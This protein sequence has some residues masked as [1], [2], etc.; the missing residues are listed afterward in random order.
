MTLRYRIYK[1]DDA[2]GPVDYAAPVATVGAPPFAVADLAAGQSRRYGVRP[3]DDVSGLESATTAAEVTLTRAASGA[4]GSDPP[5]GP[6]GVLVA[7]LASGRARVSW[8]YL[9]SPGRPDPEEF[10]IWATPGTAVDFTPAAAVLTVPAAENRMHYHAIVDSL[11]PGSVAFGVRGVRP[12]PP[13]VD[14]GNTRSVVATIAGTGPAA[15]D[16]LEST[17]TDRG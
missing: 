9:R 5:G 4:D 14:D 13:R 16:D 10:A 1:G 11:P 3:Y 8:S 15:P 17:A 6:V 7:P 2:G 12:G